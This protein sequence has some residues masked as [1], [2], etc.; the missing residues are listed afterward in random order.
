M[1]ALAVYPAIY[2]DCRG[3]E[4]TT[5]AN[6]GK[7]IRMMIRDVEFAGSGPLSLEPVVDRDDPRLSS[8]CLHRFDSG[9]VE[10][11]A[12][13]LNYQVPIPIVA[14][15]SLQQGFLNVR[16]EVG[17][18]SERGWPEPERLQITLELDGCRYQGSGTG[19]DFEA[20]LIEIQ[21][22]LPSDVYMK[23]CINCAL[24]DYSVYGKDIFGDM[25]CYRDNRGLYL[26]VRTKREYM[27][28]MGNFTE[29]VQ[30]TYLCPEFE[31]RAPGTGYRG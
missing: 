5:I 8:F 10:L 3:E 21:R 22:A 15:N 16:A 24:S 14:G 2:Q 28:I 4:T 9:A 31:R 23:A 19:G 6:D 29:D 30:E 13:S 27:E 12:Y 25:R 7:Q 26:K 20:E 1:A 17:E 18:I 11:C